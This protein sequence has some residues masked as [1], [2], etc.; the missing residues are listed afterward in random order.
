MKKI[1]NKTKIFIFTIT[2]L[3]FTN[4]SF[5]Q[6][7]CGT[8]NNLDRL[9]AT[10]PTIPSKIQQI[11]NFTQNY[12]AANQGNKANAIY[13]I[14]VVVHVVYN[15]TAQN[16]SDAQIQSQI[17]I[18]NQDFRRLNAD[19][20]NTPS[21][22]AG[23]A[24]DSEIEFCLASVSPTGAASTGI[25]RKSTTVTSFTYDDKVKYA[26]TGGSNAWPSDKYL[27]IWVCNL[28][29]GLLGYA[30]F[31][32]TGVAATDGVVL[33]FKYIGNT[34]AAVAPFNK[35]RTAT[36]EVGHW[37]N[38][39][40]IWGDATCGNDN[41]SDT[42]I[43]YTDNAGCPSHPKSNS[44]GASAEMFMNYMDYT[45]D[46]CMNIF[47]TGQ[48]NRM[49][50][51]LA[52]GGFR[53]SLLSSGGCGGGTTPTPAYCS[54][55]GTNTQYEWI[56]NIKLNTIN[57][58]SAAN[59][60]YADFTSIS[61]TLN[62]GT[63]YSVT[64][65]PAFASTTY[66]EYFKVYIDYNQDKDFDDAGELVYTSAGTTVA[67][68]GSFTVPST[69][70]IGATRMRVI[71]KDG[72]IATPCE[73]YTYGETEDYT[74][75]IQSG[76]TASCGTPASLSATSITSNG[77][78][79][80][81]G[82]ISGA[83]S[84][85]VKYKPTASTTWVTTTST[86]TSKAVT[87]LTASTGYEFQVQAV[88]SVTG[89]YSISKTFTTT[90]ATSTA[91]YCSAKGTNT[92]YEWISNI[93]LNTINN[94]S[95]ANGGYADFTSISTTLNQ[96]TAY[97][98]TCTP[99]FASTTYSEYFKVY[100][101]YNQD[102][103][104][105]DAGELVYTSAGTTVAVS[106]SFTVPS[107]ATIGATRMRVIMK[108]GAIATPCEQ[109]T[110]GETEDYTVN[111]QSGTTASCG[112]PASL[113]ATSITSNGATLN[114]G[115]ISGATSYNVKY[116]PTASTTWVTTTSTTTSKAVTGLTAS[117]GYEFQVQ[118]V[119]SVTGTYSVSKT[120]TTTAATSTVTTKTVTVGT[121]TT[122]SNVM[123]YG[124]YYMDQKSQFIITK[125]ELVAAGWTSANSY[126]RSLAFY[127][128]TASAQ[129]MNGFTIKVAHTT[130]SAY[131]STSFLAGTFTTV[132]SGN[133]AAVA[134]S[135]NTYNL[136]SAFNYNG[137]SNLLVE[138]CWNN[139]SYTTNSTVQ[140]TNTTTFRAINYRADL[141]SGGVCANTT[142][143]RTYSRPNMRF[144]FKNAATGKY[145]VEDNT[146]EI[147]EKESSASLN[148]YP[149][150]VTSVI[151]L[152]YLVNV[153]DSKV[154]ISIMNT[155]GALIYSNE[156]TGVSEG[157]HNFQIN[158][159]KDA[160]SIELPSG[161]YICTVVVNDTPERKRF[162]LLK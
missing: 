159:L 3:T 122:T 114:W 6:R 124:T 151:N 26:T 96:G 85:N 61:T 160:N 68:S 156:Q 125:D 110:Y 95:A 53:N 112:T 108:D 43:H 106:G 130:S 94:T 25:I 79:L 22:F 136:T 109:Y 4:V 74:V 126:I 116:K 71:M 72:A 35:G 150:P 101:D 148:L 143:T 14:P 10:D 31:P 139:S 98:V 134:N 57:N 8:I 51:S 99:A 54:A 5:S 78:T 77:A 107:T 146:E 137:A 162:V 128:T 111:I 115:A 44:C 60:G 129:T 147:F 23:V 34:G 36:H 141:A 86:T 69:A 89:T 157:E 158:L 140:H 37:L 144:V 154:A 145:G 52:P 102:K 32:G 46:A 2:L 76:T 155:L 87:G 84:Y 161:V 7:N 39:S 16:I 149:N 38:L 120:F 152:S 42:P 45:D 153:N 66:S 135:W 58:T 121:G 131:G 62:Q 40:H 29:G 49:R 82:A 133:V 75:N 56:S 83:T 81:W 19:R 105:D 63:A 15:T 113:S 17:A 50:A 80:N 11:E 97:S 24:A 27:N 90:A 142:G 47:S 132:Y 73:Q 138:I 1:L 33:G 118:A 93:K 91:S 127:V 21:T 9:V 30:Q 12:I 59:G 92:Q 123:P 20:V 104:F 119:C 41:V 18:L 117:T 55:K 100:I 70:T 48:K 13:S 88:C 65:T 64:C 103:D 67:V 28:G